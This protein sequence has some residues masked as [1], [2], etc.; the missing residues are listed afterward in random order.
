M[1][2]FTASIRRV[3]DSLAETLPLAATFDDTLDQLAQ[4]PRMFIEPDGSFV[5]RGTADDGQAW[6]L[7]GN[8]IDRGSVL[9][10][11]ELSGICPAERL[12]DVLQALGWPESPLVFQL[13]RVGVTL[14]EAEF[15]QQAAGPSGAGWSPR[16]VD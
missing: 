5:W 12:D 16:R 6:Q 3:G 11:V 2:R 15:R 1:L 14:T 4:L 7:D 10:Y 9:D 8:L 13:P